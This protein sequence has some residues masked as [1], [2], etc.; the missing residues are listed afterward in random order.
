MCFS[1]SYRLLLGS[2][3]IQRM[4]WW[5][6]TGQ[7]C[8]LKL[9]HMSPLLGDLGGPGKAKLLS[10]SACVQHNLEGK[11]AANNSMTERSLDSFLSP[12]AGT[13]AASEL[14]QPI[15]KRKHLLFIRLWRVNPNWVLCLWIQIVVSGVFFVLFCFFLQVTKLELDKK[16]DSWNRFYLRHL[17][18]WFQMYAYGYGNTV[19]KKKKVQSWVNI[20]I[21]NPECIPAVGFLLLL[22]GFVLRLG[23]VVQSIQTSPT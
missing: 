21:R 11:P 16:C 19:R 2:R 8:F 17:G 20:Q 10:V 3:L 18:S 22:A 15:H 12:T 6:S 23:E 14:C 5:V 1:K 4:M 7:W 9:C 13:L